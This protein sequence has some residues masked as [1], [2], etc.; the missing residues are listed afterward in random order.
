MQE[1]SENFNSLRPILFKLC[2]KTTG[3]GRIDPPPAG[4]RVKASGGKLTRPE[5]HFPGH[6]F[7]FPPATILTENGTF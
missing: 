6:L 2:K 4:I 1:N 3:G 5:F 7:Q